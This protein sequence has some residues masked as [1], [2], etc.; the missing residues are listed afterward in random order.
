[1]LALVEW[2]W[3]PAVLF[4]LLVA[5]VSCVALWPG[6]AASRRE[7]AMEILGLLL[8]R[9]RSAKPKRAVPPNGRPRNS[10]DNHP[11]C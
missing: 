11:G 10:R 4:V 3:L 8:R 5:V 1:V 9:R 2:L 6:D 7:T